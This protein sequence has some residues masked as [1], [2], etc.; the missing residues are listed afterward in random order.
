MNRKIYRLLLPGLFLLA[1]ILACELTEPEPTPDLSAA[2][3]GTMQAVAT[4]EQLT[5]EAG[6]GGEE[7]PGSAATDTPEPEVATP[8]IT[9]TPTISLTP[10][11]EVPTV[12]VSVDTNCRF[13]PGNVYQYLGALL[14]GE[15]AEVVARNSAGTYWYIRN[16][17][18]A[19]EFCWLWGEY[20]TV[21][22]DTTRLPVF[23]PPP[24]PTFT[25]V[26]FTVVAV[27]VTVDDPSW[28]GACPHK[29]TFTGTI[30]VTGAGTVTY[31]W[32]RSDNASAPVES[33]TFTGS[34]TQSVTSTW[35]IGIDYSGWKRIHILT[36]VD[37][38]S[39]MAN[40]TLDCP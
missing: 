39:N 37:T 1:S 18:I 3:T 34:G 29:F 35:Q 20:A 13:G 6:G 10:T 36:P 8:T 30:E 28:T 38:Y 40:F 11:S 26:P 12:S 33:L 15:S 7:P 16:P 14:V 5:R 27:N 21:S 31:Q 17:D 23:T 4:I 25:P 9:L 19:G 2:E 24:T 32:E 22:G